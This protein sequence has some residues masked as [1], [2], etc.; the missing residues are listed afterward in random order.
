MRRTLRAEARLE[1]LARTR[2]A[3]THFSRVRLSSPSRAMITRTISRIPKVSTIA[4][5]IL[6]VTTIVASE[7]STVQRS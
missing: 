3:A 2:S 7:T 1:S 6:L 5:T 4:R